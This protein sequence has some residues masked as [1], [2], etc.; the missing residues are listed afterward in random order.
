MDF[1][2]ISHQNKIKQII[3]QY[4]NIKVNL[5]NCGIVKIC[6]NKL[7][8]Y[9]NFDNND[10][11]IFYSS[12]LIIPDNINIYLIRHAQAIH[13]ITSKFKR[14]FVW[15]ADP[16]I[17]IEGLNQINELI[18]FIKNNF[19]NNNNENIFCSSELY[20]S[21]QTAFK[22]MRGLNENKKILI[23]PNIGEIIFE[24]ELINNAVSTFIPE[25]STSNDVDSG[26]FKNY[27]EA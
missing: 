13:N 24:N 18:L 9:N 15:N 10:Y 20:R 21:Q 1:Y 27:A 26:G 12:N 7:Y 23:L 4:F 6:K 16:S 5:P 11:K 22:L 19:Y 25:L 2:I 8:L 3:N 14:I 17:T